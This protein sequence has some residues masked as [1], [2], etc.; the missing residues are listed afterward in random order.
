M[1]TKEQTPNE[2]DEK[3]GYVFGVDG[4]LDAE[5]TKTFLSLSDRQL[6]RL[7]DEGHIRKGT[8]P[9]SHHRVFCRKSIVDFSKRLED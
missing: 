4:L 7:A 1:K 2:A 9:G 6:N 5:A 8:L 3:F